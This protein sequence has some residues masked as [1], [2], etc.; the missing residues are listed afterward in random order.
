MFPAGTLRCLR[1]ISRLDWSFLSMCRPAWQSVRIEKR[2]GSCREWWESC[3]LCMYQVT[4]ASME[5]QYRSI[6]W[7]ETDVSHTQNTTFRA[8]AIQ[9]ATA[10][11]IAKS[12]TW[13]KYII[14]TWTTPIYLEF[15]LRQFDVRHCDWC[16]RLRVFSS[17]V[18]LP[19]VNRENANDEWYQESIIGI[20]WIQLRIL[21]TSQLGRMSSPNKWRKDCCV[22]VLR[23]VVVVFD[24]IETRRELFVSWMDCTRAVAKTRLIVTRSRWTPSITMRLYLLVYVCCGSAMMASQWGQTESHLSTLSIYI[25]MH[26]GKWHHGRAESYASHFSSPFWTIHMLQR[27]VKVRHHLHVMAVKLSVDG[28]ANP[29]VWWK[30]YACVLDPK[31]TGVLDLYH[32]ISTSKVIT[33]LTMM[34]MFLFVSLIFTKQRMHA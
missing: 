2:V 34:P 29:L 19:E 17:I 15:C 31:V 16:W 11:Q 24:R 27:A 30:W 23:V 5:L 20:Q 28:F 7:D 22:V 21:S 9:E 6:H 14:D 13:Y 32:W 10:N 8:V 12:N 18:A 1:R 33:P 26:M 25:E 4:C 3:K